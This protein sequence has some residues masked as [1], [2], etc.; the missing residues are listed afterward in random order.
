MRRYLWIFAAV[1]LYATGLSFAQ[2]N[3]A[4]RIAY[5]DASN[6]LT[7][8]EIY[9][10][11]HVIYLSHPPFPSLAALTASSPRTTQGFLCS[12]LLLRN[13]FC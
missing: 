9:M 7:G 8:D 6:N 12:L 1:I 2:P 5:Q 4:K 13:V 3:T 11:S 10:I